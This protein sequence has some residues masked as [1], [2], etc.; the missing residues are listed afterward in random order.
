[1]AQDDQVPGM[2]HE[3]DPAGGGGESRDDPNATRPGRESLDS[4]EILRQVRAAISGSDERLEE[5]T[6][7]SVERAKTRATEAAN[8]ARR[9]PTD[10]A[11]TAARQAQ[12][13][14][15]QE[16]KQARELGD[17]HRSVLAY[18]SDDLERLMSGFVSG[19]PDDVEPKPAQEAPDTATKTTSSRS[20]KS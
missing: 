11:R 13:D 15:R 18:L 12:Q 3:H 14:A 7:K 6:R 19:A 20:S 8:L 4:A 10:E 1:M 2:N 16:A 17:L 9:V 5:M